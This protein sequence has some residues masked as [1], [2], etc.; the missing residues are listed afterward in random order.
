MT[1]D[2]PAFEPED[3]PGYRRREEVAMYEIPQAL[4]TL[5]MFGSDLYLGLQANNIAMVD[6]FLMDV[7]QDVLEKLIREERTPP[8]TMFLNA[9]SQMWIFAAYEILRTWRQRVSDLRTWKEKGKLE[10]QLAKFEANAGYRHFGNDIRADQ[11]KQVIEDTTVIDGIDR[12][13]KRS[14][15]PFRRLEFVRIA[16]AKH[17]VRRQKF[18][19]SLAP[20]YGRINYSCGSLDYELE[21]GSYSMGTISRRDVADEIRALSFN[22][23]P[24]PD[25]H[26]Q[27]FDDF[28][29]GKGFESVREIFDPR[30]GTDF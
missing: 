4:E 21:N 3:I 17:E 23:D 1:N 16:M 27:Q 30:D 7:E 24:P 8:E 28:M 25:D 11:I 14:H 10:E 5:T 2:D 12:D 20:G 6:Q 18:S 13:L 26:L 29:S 22:D 19:A 9:Q 15:I